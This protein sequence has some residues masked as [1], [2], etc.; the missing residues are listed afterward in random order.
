MA[1]IYGQFPSIVFAKASTGIRTAA[2]LAGKKV[3]IPGRFGSSWIMLQALLADADLT[4]EDVEIVEYPDFGQGAAVTQGAVAAATGFANNEPV[5]LELTGEEV[6]ILRVDDIVPLPGNGLIVGT[7]TLDAKSDAI[8]GF[9]AA[10]LRAMEE[11]AEKPQV[12]LDAAITA[13]PELG[14]GS[15]GAGRHPRCHDR[16]V[17]GTG[18]GGA[19]V[20]GHR[21]RGL[22]AVDRVSRDARSGAEPGHGR[23]RHRDRPVAGA[24][25]TAVLG[26]VRPTAAR[27]SWWLREALAAEA[28]AAPHLAAAAPPL[29]GTT[30]ADVVIVGG[31]YTG[32]WT[33]LRLTELEPSARV[34]LIESDICGGGPSGRNG[35]FVTNWWDELPT[36]IDR[37]GVPGAI[38]VG[39]AMEAAVDEV[40]AF[41]AANDVDAWFTKAGSLSASAA[42]AQDGGWM[43]AVTALREHGLGDR[44]VPLTADEVRA[45]VRSPVFREGA[46]MPGAATVQPATLARGLRRVL[47]ERGVIIHEGTT[48]AEIDGQRPGWLGALGAG[49]RRAPRR[50]GAAGGP[51]PVRVRTT[52]AAGDGEVL[53]GSAVLALNAW[54]GAWPWFGPRLVTWSSYIVL[55][56]PIPDRLADI[57]WT[58]G[59]GVADARFTLHY[60]RT[61]PDGRIAIGGGGGRA[62]FAGRIGPA[63]TDSAADAARAAA[64]LRRLFPSLR[65][66]RIEDAWGG[67]ID[68]SAD[69]LPWFG[70]VRGRPIHYGHG[71]SGNGVGPAV[72]GGRILAARAVERADDPALA[73]ALADG[74]D[75][76]GRSRRNRRATL[77]RG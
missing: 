46:F 53:A 44:L 55:T 20:R 70:S 36:L 32:L 10:T 17:E 62:G 50:R 9:I 51:R 74:R 19:R 54:A 39:E 13:V 30:T 61:T 40:G 47:L 16:G 18:T 75:R 56:E 22:G 43:P 68:I 49:T 31:G 26:G 67:P 76:R 6:T 57:G 72:V 45:R 15:G 2:D 63:F 23:R 38:G 8:A 34:V 14:F 71:Y 66:V 29:R 60:L 48:A 35:G 1:T 33:A 5:Q 59:E 11:I 25:L 21:A 69:H 77:A 58:G 37:Y 64:G 3:G 12:G 65:D 27:R 73:L 42:P 24:G 7:S 41:C 28:A 52:S 4:P